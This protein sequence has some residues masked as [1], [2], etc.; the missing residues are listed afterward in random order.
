MSGKSSQARDLKT[1]ALH[2]TIYSGLLFL[3]FIFVLRFGAAWLKELFLQHRHEYALVAILLMIVQAVVLE[4]VSF[5]ILTR[6][7]GKR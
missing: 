4:T 2:L 3:Y 5:S 1:F 6:I 7:R